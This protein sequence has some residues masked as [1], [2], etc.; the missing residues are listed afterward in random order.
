[1]LKKPLCSDINNEQ[2]HFIYEF[3]IINKFF[4]ISI[5]IWLLR[6][7]SL[8]SYKLTENWHMVSNRVAESSRIKNKKAKT[9]LPLQNTLHP[10]PFPT[11]TLPVKFSTLQFTFL[12]T[13]IKIFLRG[14]NSFNCIVYLFPFLALCLVLDV[15]GNILFFCFS[16]L[17]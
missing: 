13:E 1:M 7:C 11:L 17:N 12:I 8:E 3:K 16:R 6:K 10:I 5:R 4:I 15:N 14:I 2:C 9:S